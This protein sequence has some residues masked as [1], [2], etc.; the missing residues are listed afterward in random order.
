[1]SVAVG[2]AGLAVT[3]AYLDAKLGIS[4]DIKEIHHRRKAL[5]VNQNAG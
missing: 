2:A 1:M 3:A 5:Q 4:H